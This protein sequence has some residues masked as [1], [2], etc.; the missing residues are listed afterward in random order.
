[1]ES[2]GGQA[3]FTKGASNWSNESCVVDKS[4]YIPICRRS[5]ICRVI[6]ETNVVTLVLCDS[7]LFVQVIMRRAERK[8][9]LSQKVVGD[10]YI[11]QEAEEI[12]VNETGGLRSIIFGLHI[13]DQGQ[14]DTEKPG[15]FEVS[16][17]SAMAERVI[18][19]R[20][21]KLS[22]KDDGKFLVNPM[23]LSDD[24]DLSIGEG[25]TNA[26]FDPGLDEV[27]YRSWI[28]KFKEASQSGANQNMELGNR[29][30]VSR[31]KSLK[32]EAVKKKAEEKKLSKWDALGYHSLT[33]EDPILPVDGDL[34]SD[35]GSVH[36]VYGDCTHP[37]IHCIS[38]PTIAFRFE[39]YAFVTLAKNIHDPLFYFV[40]S[41]ILLRTCYSWCLFA[42]LSCW[43]LTAKDPILKK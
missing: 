34:I 15:E 39:L 2:T 31:D 8:L 42:L 25:T 36:F 21:K 5:K 1:M 19:L 22:N 43:Y 12:A 4:C 32:L 33:V 29:K 7:G 17:V 35:S 16:N 6:F 26:N 3:S 28:E 10:D 14:M 38:E 23:N 27:S 24:C 13:F 11:D 20:H 30:T 18:A 40:F 37:S 9:Q 41:I